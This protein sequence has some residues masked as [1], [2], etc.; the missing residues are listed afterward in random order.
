MT[1][2][3]AVR[4]ALA[5]ALGTATLAPA[6]TTYLP[7][8]AEVTGLA[9]ARFSS[10]LELT[11]PGASAVSATIGLVPMSGRAAP[12][13]VTRS[14]A[15]GESLRIKEALKSLFGIEDGG[16]GTIVVS[17]D[18]A[19]LASLTTR[20]VAAV[21]GAY[22][23]GLLAVAEAD[24]LGTGETGH[25]I[26]VSQSADPR[27]GYRTNL[28]VTL[29]DAGTVVEVRVLDAEG[30]VAGS[31]TLTAASP[32]VW[33]QPVAA[34]TG[35]IDLPVGR[36]EFAVKAGRATAYAVVNDNVTSDAIALQSE[37]VPPGASDRLVSGAAYSPGH[38]GSFWVTDLRLFNPGSTPLDATIQSVGAPSEASIVIPVP[39]QGVVEVER[40]LSLLGFPERTASALRVK[41]ASPLLVAAR[42][43][44]VDPA[45]VR[46]G[47]FSA[48]QFVTAWPSGLLA[49]GSTGFFSGVD[50]TLNV[51]GVRTN[52]ALVGG[53]EGAAGSLVL[54]DA[55]GV[56]QGR[57][58]FARGPG[59]WGQ[60]GVGD[61]FAA[62][63]GATSTL[64]GLSLATVP[65]NARI[66][67]NVDRGAL[68]AFVSHIDNGS[69]DAVTRPVALPGGGECSKVAITE[70]TVAPLPVRPGA[71][72]T[73]SWT[74]LLDPPTSGLTSQ[75]IRFDGEPEIELDKDARSFAR[76]FPSS[77]ARTA[78]LTVRRGSCV[79][80]RQLSFVVCADLAI[81]PADLPDGTVG[82]PYSAT[83]TSPAGTPPLTFALLA[84]TLPREL[85]LSPLGSIS[86]EPTQAGTSRFT[87]GVTDANGCTGSREYEVRIDCPTLRISPASLPAGT[88]GTAY[89]VEMRVGGGSGVG[90]WSAEGLPPG[91]SISADGQVSGTPTLAGSYP[92]TV[93]YADASGCRA[94][95]SYTLVVCNELAVSPAT[96][97]DGTAGVA[98]AAV[99]FTAA[100]AT[101]AATWAVTAGSLPAGMALDGGTGVLSGTPTVVG[102]FPFT[103]TAT[104]S[105]GCTGSVAVTLTVVCP[106]IA[107][108]PG[109]LGNGIAGV[110]YPSVTLTQTGG[111][112]AVTWAVTTGALPAG[113]AL[114]PG[115]GVLS[116]TPTVT[117]TFN[118]TVTATDANACSGTRAYTLTIDC[119]SITVNPA[120]V[121]N[122][123]AGAGYSG[124]TFTQA[125]GVGTITWTVSAGS[126]PTGMQLDAA[127]GLLSGTP[128]VTGAFPITV[129]AT[130]ANLC[131][132]E[133]ALTL[134][135]DCPTI[136]VNP[137]AIPNGT[138]GV[139]YAGA[140]F[141][142]AG[143]VGTIT[144]SLSAGSLPTGMQLDAATGLLSG[145]PLQTG[146]FPITVRA[147]DANACFGE[148]V[149]TLT[150]DCPTIAINPSSVPN[151]TT[152]VAYAGATFTQTGGVGT[153]TWSLSSGSLPTGL[154]FSTTGVLSGTPTQAGA[155]PITVRATDSNGC[156]GERAL[157]LTIVCPTI[158]VGP[159]TL[160]G[161][162]VGTSY[163]QSVS[164][165]GG[166]GTYLYSVVPG[167]LPPGLSLAGASGVISGTPTTAGLY[168]FTVTATDQY[169]CSGATAY[170]VRIC[171]VVT[172]TPATAPQA[173]INLP[174][175]PV[176]FGQT[177]G[178]LAIAW[179]AT[180]LPT[181]LTIDAAS[182]ALS[183]TP[184]QAGAFSVTVT[185]TD[186][187]GCA[188][189]VTFTLRVCPDMAISPASLAN[190]VVGTA[191]GPVTFSQSGS[192]APIT[193]S[194]TGLPAGLTLDPG[195]GVLSGTPEA[196]GSSN[197]VVT[198]TDANGC[199]VSRSYT[200][201]IDC[202]AI[203]LAPGTLPAGTPG[204]AYSATISASSA[205]AGGTYGFTVFSGSLPPGLTLS[206]GGALTGSPTAVGTFDFTVR[207]TH[208]PSGCTGD[209]AY[210]I[211]VTCA[212]I[213][214]G[215][216]APPTGVTA[217]V[218]GYTHTFTASG[219][220]APHVFS[221]TGT[222][223]P[224]LTLS[225]A[226]V[227][228]GTPTAAG[229]FNFTIVATDAATGATCTGS[230]PFSVTVVC[231]TI[232]VN[233][234]TLP[235]GSLGV[236]YTQGV[237][238][239]GGTGT[240]TFAVTAGTLPT[241]LTLGTDGSITGQPTAA[242]TF[243]FTV[244]ATDT[245]TSCTSSRAYTVNVC[246]VITLTAIATCTE[247]GAAYS[248]TI[249]APAGAPTV[250]FAVTAGNLPP[251]LTLAPN[252]TLSGNPTTAGP[253]VFTVTATDGNSCTGS[254]AYTVNVLGLTPAAGALPEATFGSAYSQ[255]FTASGGSGG[256][257]HAVTSG[258]IPGGLTLSAAGVLSGTPTGATG[259]GSFSFTVTATNTATGCTIARA[260][261][262]VSRPV[263]A[264]NTYGDG[265]G[266]TQYAAGGYA[267]APTT[268]FVASA[269]NILGNDLGPSLV[270]SVVTGPVNGTV[271]MNADGSF[272]YTPTP[273]ATTSASFTYKVTSNGVDSANATVTITLTGRVWYVNSAAA[274]GN[275]TSGSPFNSMGSA[276]TASGTGDIV[277]VHTGGATTP[278]ALALEA[279][280]VLWGQGTAFSLAGT[281]LSIPAGA[282]PTLTG[283]VTL[284][285]SN[286][287]VSSV[288][289]STSSATGLTDNQAG[290]ITGITVQNNV[291]V[292]AANAAAVDLT[293]V[294]ASASGI[295][296]TSL[297][298]TNS[299]GKGVNLAGVGGSLTSGTTTVTNPAGIGIDIQTSVAGGTISL[300]PTSA[301]A[302]G[303]TGVN[304]ASNAGNV[305]FGALTVTPDANQRGLLA[306]ENA[307]TL[308]VPSGT[309]TTTGAT[310]VEITRS[311]GTTP[312]SVSLTTVN[313]NGG[314][315][316]IYLRRTSG[317]FTVVGTGA[318]GSGG[319]I[320]NMT[321]AD[322]AVAGS[323]IFLDNATNVSLSRMQLNDFQNFAI[324]G[325]AVTGFSLA[326]STIN[327]T[328][329]NN[330]GAD[331]G[332]VSFSNLTG[333]A[334][335]TA[336]SFSGAV[337]H[338]V[339]VV[340]TAGTLNRITVT[341]STFG[342]M[343]AATGSD[344]L[345]IE[346]LGTAVINAT[347]QNN[348]FT[349]AVGDHFQYSVNNSVT[350]DVVF[351]GNT[352]TNSMTAVSGG[353]GIRFVGGSNVGGINAGMT[354]DVS[355]NTI[356]DS[357]G[358]A[359][360]VNKLGGTGNYTGTIAN[361]QVGV[362]AALNSGSA[363]GS[364]IFFLTDGGGTY[365][366]SVTG[367]QVR[368][369][370]NYGIFMQTGGSGVVGNGN[371]RAT[372]T[373][374]TVSN[375][376]NL[377]FAKNGFHLNGGV[378]M[379]DTYSICLTLGGAG[380][381]ANS[382]TGTGTDGG[383]DFRLRQRQSTTVRLPGYAFGATDTAAVVSFVQANNN[384]GVAPT[385]SAAVSSPP[386]FG[387]LGSACPF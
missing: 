340:N 57:T 69:G 382:L 33:Q 267:P 162:T 265:A 349:A 94:S 365:V 128:L 227:L 262:L 383:T 96:L 272:L 281:G 252:G 190:G 210:S 172:V 323:G 165:G 154:A 288:D 249:T 385:G 173:T 31:T 81:E 118:F 95:S 338:N 277:F 75:S 279:S 145:T 364:G 149:L 120:A 66:D 20:N 42:T 250:A 171:P 44:N 322:G 357:R 223:P 244:T 257:T 56:E 237:S 79:K 46:A 363:E 259:T 217:G 30:R 336:C 187:N 92:V 138:G 13:P 121:P 72:T 271:S 247:V 306:T 311:A 137:A 209:Q 287:V 299:P 361:N 344:G 238:A 16:A 80:T 325:D 169:G 380:A 135:V 194:A 286:V 327:G 83:L 7:G 170:S 168:T 130:D 232:T 221:H 207:A 132:G 158:A 386:G 313:A 256:F 292:T 89:G 236:A 124:A 356:R 258:S 235:D 15:A 290:A 366:V 32:E 260:Y 186:A 273:G 119:P 26:W 328:N 177:G 339:A 315:N 24:L 283:T 117:G 204:T 239:T 191:Y 105:L 125:G 74:V 324:R 129:R 40:V 312:L 199:S 201:V 296:F 289:V 161:G 2:R 291:T 266:N 231:P 104:D 76:A 156:F 97:P 41:A 160:P 284:G 64:S 43:N 214:I 175:G 309:V 228:S 222:L 196:P 88:V 184:T 276:D 342:T 332:S 377:V 8:A 300:G 220:L 367:N 314:S 93:R 376:G 90:T 293:G 384:T 305:T 54:R 73:F 333:S 136:A 263:A 248:S 25:S 218:A 50:Q 261:T 254:Q 354:F 346:S 280:Q 212:T 205:L 151:G 111:V 68:D 98:Y 134:T 146:S 285:G 202:P 200:L 110:A 133:R 373:G 77:G 203:S 153:I 5:I 150:I 1:L 233:P 39:A 304:L 347:V 192:A 122:G 62:S 352:I 197:I 226:G 37:R 67:V 61:W 387:F 331:E 320:Q 318:A 12:V 240:Y 148:R 188:G 139:A 116:G 301:T 369:Y 123:T 143:G 140:T 308:T 85:T 182:G 241:G 294:S 213:T 58:T 82:S 360:A 157:T 84:G 6:E 176:A 65:E 319:T 107:I 295:T 329:G 108:S 103:V 230:A 358:T 274:A 303:G 126:L 49:A 255:T 18:T 251:G 195:T 321:G 163:S 36:A 381:L 152:G 310:A 206:A 27:T 208:S 341:G 246:P 229:T 355:N 183:G 351:T 343:N 99:P 379:G 23:L 28:S 330:A 378:T 91:L 362:A 198:A 282:K 253:Y 71:G 3:Y 225:T 353:G 86:G 47:T 144:W 63:L 112:G 181:G 350:G 53:P 180:G 142:Q 335:I 307:G 17:S 211:S 52:L 189:A 115:T 38:L 269:T 101:G 29:V 155:F 219:G 166:G 245:V 264:G 374:N 127:T 317:S 375:P 60:L 70:F 34:L 45:G 109:T 100:G 147:T 216:G 242:G 337:E 174:Y 345:L 316:G 59:E 14:L 326:N 224:G 106:T 334:S 185:A 102:T 243:T 11:N 179:S 371:I 35:A 372:V 270:P 278:G 87:V 164:A 9:G 298:S 234:A 348:F 297:T 51:P 268:P 131:F 215:G 114:A 302:S 368:Q 178:A 370:G 159:A 4:F 193:W 19:L 55:L 141:T 10:T 22:G 48:Q 275:G 78:T 167:T 21:E 359:I 113:M